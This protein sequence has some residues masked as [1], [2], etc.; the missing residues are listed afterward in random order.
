MVTALSP[1]GWGYFYL[2]DN[3][4]RI[5][6]Y[7][8]WV[9]SLINISR[10]IA[11]QLEFDDWPKRYFNSVCTFTVSMHWIFRVPLA[12]FWTFENVWGSRSRIRNVWA[13][14]T[15]PIEARTSVKIYIYN[16]SDEIRLIFIRFGWMIPVYRWSW[17]I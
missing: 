5:S 13:F 12:F 7:V 10:N 1:Q 16:S 4:V 6:V 11:G 8:N 2:S 15:I 3:E 17:K 14:E 9:I